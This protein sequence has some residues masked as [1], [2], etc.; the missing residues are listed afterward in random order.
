MRSLLKCK[1]KKKG[2][3][4][5]CDYGLLRTKSIGTCRLNLSKVTH[6]IRRFHF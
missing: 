3:I 1:N 6:L 4:G 2:L 5:S